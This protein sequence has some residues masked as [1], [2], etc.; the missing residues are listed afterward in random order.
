MCLKGGC[1]ADELDTYKDNGLAPRRLT[2]LT[3]LAS[4]RL[5]DLRHEI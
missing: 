1:K 4:V 5:S 2:H 3:S